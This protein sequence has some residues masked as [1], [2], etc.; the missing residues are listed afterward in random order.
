M[1]RPELMLCL[2]STRAGAVFGVDRTGAVFVVGQEPTCDPLSSSEIPVQAAC[3]SRW[4]SPHMQPVCGTDGPPVVPEVTGWGPAD[5][6]PGHRGTRRHVLAARWRDSAASRP[7]LADGDWRAPSP[8]TYLPGERGRPDHSA[9]RRPA[10]QPAPSA[11]AR[12][13]WVART[14]RAARRGRRFRRSVS[15]SGRGLQRRW[16]S[17]RRLNYAGVGS[18]A[19]E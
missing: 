1:S 16:V 7:Q 8:P 17:R 15:V 13:A 14:S 5:P 18:R 2:K 11:P 3:V 6:R 19:T 4:R 10:R 9:A 12:R